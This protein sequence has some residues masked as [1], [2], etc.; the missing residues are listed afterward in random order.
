MACNF[1]IFEYII[2]KFEYYNS[3]YYNFQYI[4]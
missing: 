4:I 1:D 3:E 2:L